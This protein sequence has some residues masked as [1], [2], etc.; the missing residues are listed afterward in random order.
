[1][2]PSVNLPS[3]Q[4]GGRIPSSWDYKVRCVVNA[5][6]PPT[7]WIR[8]RRVLR[9]EEVADF[10]ANVFCSF[11]H[12]LLSALPLSPQHTAIWL[13]SPPFFQNSSSSCHIR[14]P[15]CLVSQQHSLGLPIA[16][17]NTFS[18]AKVSIIPHLDSSAFSREGCQG[19][20]SAFSIPSMFSL[21]IISS[22]PTASALSLG[23]WLPSHHLLPV[24]F[25]Q[26]SDSHYERISTWIPKRQL[27]LHIKSSK[28]KLL[29]SPLISFAPVFPISGNDTAFHTATPVENPHDSLFFSLFI[30]FI[31]KSRRSYHQDSP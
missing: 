2:K 23:W 29:I 6:L 28:T 21:Q 26:T 16:Y 24:P 20:S 27:N 25:S 8:G 5:D 31:S 3:D 19:L 17:R 18:C 13:R 10:A 4:C 22:N 15:H 11:S 12:R 1:M 7:L 30:W 9:R 14:S